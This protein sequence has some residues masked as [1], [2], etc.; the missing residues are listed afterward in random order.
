MDY[1][2][3]RRGAP[4]IVSEP[5]LLKGL[6]ADCQI[7]SFFKPSHIFLR[8]VLWQEKLLWVSSNLESFSTGCYHP[9]SQL[10]YEPREVLLLYPAL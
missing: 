6:A 8:I 3:S 5:S 4:I 1:T 9:G 10:H 2:I 7:F